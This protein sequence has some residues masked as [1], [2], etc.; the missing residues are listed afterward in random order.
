[1][2]TNYAKFTINGAASVDSNNNAGVNVTNGQTL[3]LTLETNPAPVLSATYDVYDPS[4][5]SSPTKSKDAP[6]IVFT[7]SSTPTE[8]LANP[9]GSVTIDMPG[10]GVHS[11]VIRCT[12]SLGGTAT[13]HT[14]ERLVAIQASTVP[15]IRK[16]VP[17]ET[18]QYDQDGFSDEL[19]DMVDAIVS[20]ASSTHDPITLASSATVG[21]L[22]LFGQEI[23]NQASSAV[24]SAS[25]VVELGQ[26]NATSYRLRQI[27]WGADN[28]WWA[29]GDADENIFRYDGG[30][31]WTTYTNASETS[32]GDYQYHG[33]FDGKLWTG[34]AFSPASPHR[35]W[36][37][38]PS[39]TTWTGHGGDPESIIPLGF[40]EYDGSIVV[41]ALSGKTFKWVS[42]STWTDLGDVGGSHRAYSPVVVGSTLYVMTNL[43]A[44]FRYDGG[45]T[46]TD[47]SAP[48]NDVKC[49]ADWN[50][51]LVCGLLDSGTPKVYKYDGSWTKLGDNLYDISYSYFEFIA[52]DQNGILYAR[53]SGKSTDEFLKY[54]Q[55]ANTWEP[56]LSESSTNETYRGEFNPLNVVGYSKQNSYVSTFEDSETTYSNGY[57]QGADWELFNNKADLKPVY[58]LIDGA[59]ITPDFNNGSIQKVTIGG[60]RTIANPLNKQSGATYELII[61]QDGTGSRTL[62]WGSDYLWPGGAAPTLSTGADDIDIIRFTCDGNNLFGRLVGNNFS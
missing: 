44:V 50:G 40:A 2:S 31:T 49:I 55:S 12:V 7:G 32:T 61:K 59:T 60:N 37:F 43:G 52:A 28:T 18:N 15:A 1:M 53:P 26:V 41:S 14:Y 35:V 34:A 5:T 9:N 6:N 21:G 47:L 8:V 39:T 22:S 42:G 11:Y 45:T 25:S 20:A 33:W 29:T 19:N 36:S 23:G 16:T 62:L 38:D 48:G 54:N 3:T 10:S 17:N 30:T 24:E 13:D 56:A 46:W 51:T 58:I 4:D 27:T 57:L